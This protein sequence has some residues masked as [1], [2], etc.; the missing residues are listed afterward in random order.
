MPVVW[1]MAVVLRA[2]LRAGRRGSFE[3]TVVSVSSSSSSSLTSS[4]FMEETADF[5]LFRLRLDGGSIIS[6]ISAIGSSLA[7]L[8]PSGESVVWANRA[9]DARVVRRGG[10]RE[11]EALLKTLAASLETREVLIAA[12]YDQLIGDKGAE[13]KEK[14]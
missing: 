6:S 2:G 12:A 11:S 14:Y 8:L 7:A 13:G 1:S 9:R 10:E 5:A 4:V 3:G